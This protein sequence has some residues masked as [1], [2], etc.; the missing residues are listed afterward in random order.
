[1]ATIKDI[2]KKLNVSPATVSKALNGYGDLSDATVARVQKACEEL[3]Y[4]PNAAARM[5]KNGRS[6]NIGV[7]FQDDTDEQGGLT[8]EYFSIIL[9]NAKKEAESS[10]YDLT[11]INRNISD[12]YLAHCKYRDFDGV[13]IVT[14]N[15]T[16]RDVLD[17][18]ESDIPLV[19]IDYSYDSHSSVMSDNV[20]GGYELTKY[21]MSQGHRKIAFIH[22]EETSVTRKRENGFYKALDESGVIIPQEYI[23]LGIF[24]DPKSSGIATR[25]LMA[26]PDRPTAIMYPDDISYLGGLTELEK[27][28]LSIPD[29]ISVTGYDGI[30]LASLLRPRLTTYQ[31][32]ATAIG[33]TAMYLLVQ[34]IENPKLFEP[35]TRKVQGLLVRGQ[36]VKNIST[37]DGAK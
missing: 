8:H 26:L 36:T 14:S 22:G 20:A 35:E 9:N 15:Y 32:D 5:L 3:H 37:S 28:G 24:H 19:S 2:A 12:S 23:K 13:L 27:E 4:R 6:K 21:L 10:G 34:N 7:I 1:M 30:K 29:D 11:F 31:Q 16:G 18:V 17:L 25:E 33:K